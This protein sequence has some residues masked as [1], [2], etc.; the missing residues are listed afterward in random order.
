MFFEYVIVRVKFLVFFLQSLSLGFSFLTYA[1]VELELLRHLLKLLFFSGAQIL[2]ILELISLS[3]NRLLQV[4]HVNRSLRLLL[5]KVYLGFAERSHVLV[6]VA[7]I[8]PLNMLDCL[9][10]RVE[11]HAKLIHFDLLCLQKLIAL[12]PLFL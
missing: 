12:L 4:T 9:I 3:I 8:K 5:V 11:L 10:S 7:L 1:V 2:Q 6:K